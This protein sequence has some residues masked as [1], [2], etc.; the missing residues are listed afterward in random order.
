M[1]MNEASVCP[2]RKWFS[3]AEMAALL[4]IVLVY[5]SGAAWYAAT[6][7][8]WS[9]DSG[10]RLVQVQAIL[11]HGPAWWVSYPAQSLDPQH[12]NG[13]LSFFE[14]NHDG[15]TYIFYSFLFAHLSAFFF[16]HFGFFGL[17][18]LPMLG[19]VLT[20]VATL[21]IARLL[22]LR[23]PI[24]P[25][26]LTAL[27]TP[28]ALFSIVFWDHSITTGVAAGALYLALRG[29]ETGQL[30][31]WLAAGALLG[32]GLWL[33]EILLPYLPALVVGAWWM[34]RHH[35]WLPAAALLGVGAM[36]LLLPL[37]LINK[38]V[39]GTPM[40]PHLSNNRL[41]SPGAIIG[42]MLSPSQWGPG[43]LYT[44]FG[45]GD[46]SPAFTWQI[47]E[48]LANPWPQFQQEIRASVWMSIPFVGWMIVAASGLW[49]RAWWLCWLLLFGVAGAAWWVLSH[50]ETPHSSFLVCPLLLLAFGAARPRSKSHRVQD[51]GA[52]SPRL[53]GQTVA[54][55]TATYTLITLAKPTLGGTEWGARHLMV[56]VPALVLLAWSAVESLLPTTGQPTTGQNDASASND[57]EHAAPGRGA[58]PLLGAAGV[59]VALSVAMQIHGARSI[60][61][62]HLRNRVL[63]DAIASAPDDV[64]VTAVWWAAMNGAPSYNKK[65]ILYAGDAEHPATPLFGRMAASG[66]R[67]FTL[68]APE[69][70]NLADFAQPFGYFPIE[71]TIRQTSHSLYLNRFGR[72][73]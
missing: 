17:A 31:R 72:I 46:T 13:S 4:M 44:L 33:H 19:G 66:V 12:Q 23:F 57:E 52:S 50:N 6:G 34:R 73:D 41:G 32:A 62:G 2:G 53:L 70:Y 27:A 5:L 54:I 47:N 20:A 30:W 38:Q 61:E 9:P 40:G 35:R 11:E 18:I 14:F 24:L 42:F 43:A 65:K 58:R 69:P 16:K 25:M 29:I 26:L 21:L 22:H 37:A 36:V 59:L 56:T 45:W 1:E 60:H 48:W 63:G 15:R 51:E 68:I 49:R 67:T 10:A 55:V 7:A 28:L 71:G 64:I 39:Y 3:R 8:I